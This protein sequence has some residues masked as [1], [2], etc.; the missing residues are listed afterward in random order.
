MDC[1]VCNDVKLAMS[2][3]QGIEIDY[4]PKCRGVWLDRGELD[5]LIERSAAQLEAPPAQLLDVAVVVSAERAGRLP[6]HH[7]GWP[8]G[9][10]RT[11]EPA[12]VGQ[13]DGGAQGRVVADRGLPVVLGEP[14]GE[15]SALRGGQ[16][17]AG[18][19]RHD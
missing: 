11:G 8:R 17:P 6:E 13:R 2:D 9:E 16:L 10:A 12:P 18:D 5:K 4:C 7:H 19:A 15:R 1:P 3:R 14:A